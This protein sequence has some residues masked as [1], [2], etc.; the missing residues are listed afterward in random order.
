MIYKGQHNRNISQ[1]TDQDQDGIVDVYREWLG[2]QN[3]HIQLDLIEI[4]DELAANLPQH[5]PEVRARYADAV[6]CAILLA[7]RSL[8][9]KTNSFN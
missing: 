5:L 1:I 2:E 4:R 6:I 8:S 3:G 9:N 7:S